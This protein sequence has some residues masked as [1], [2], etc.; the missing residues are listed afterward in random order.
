[1]KACMSTRWVEFQRISFCSG[2]RCRH[3]LLTLARDRLWDGAI[4]QLRWVWPLL[5]GVAG[6][7]GVVFRYVPLKRVI[8]TV[9]SC[10]RKLSALNSCVNATTKYS[11]AVQ[12]V[13]H[14][15]RSTSWRWTSRRWC[16]GKRSTTAH[17]HGQKKK[18]EKQKRWSEE[19][20][21]FYNIN[22]I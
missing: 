6:S 3:L 7:N 10:T 13:A 5:K 19:R 15:V 21:P 22:N 4:K 8:W 14:L 16:H 20:K 12:R 9:S 18:R 1:M 2:A 11:S 17:G